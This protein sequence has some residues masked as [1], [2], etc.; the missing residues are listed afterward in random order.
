MLES[1]RPSR[2]WYQ[3]SMFRLMVVV[4]LI[5]ILLGLTAT[6]GG[7][8][9]LAVVSVVWCLFPTPLIVCAIF[10]KRD[11]QAFAVG[12]LVPWTTM[13][14]TRM[15]ASASILTA[16]IWLLA[17]GGVCGAVAVATRRWLAQSGNGHLGT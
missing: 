3:F 1:K 10:G 14:L 5:A 8:L 2:P 6:F 13:T 7:L 16:S 15:L 4:T 12:A 17:M 9:E 11:V